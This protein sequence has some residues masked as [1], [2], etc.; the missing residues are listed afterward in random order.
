MLVWSSCTILIKLLPD[1]Y[2]TRSSFYQQTFEFHFFTARWNRSVSLCSWA[3]NMD[4]L[5]S[6][7]GRR[8]C[9]GWSRDSVL[10][11]TIL[12]RAFVWSAVY[13]IAMMLSLHHIFQLT[14]ANLLCWDISMRCTVSLQP[15]KGTAHDITP[16]KCNFCLIVTFIS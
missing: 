6:T 15:V 8:W 3:S 14:K 9:L 12:K 16:V 11:Q 4:W 5:P 2:F 1:S 7:H 13:L 10:Q